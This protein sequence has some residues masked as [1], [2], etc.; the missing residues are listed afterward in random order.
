MDKK[1]FCQDRWSVSSKPVSSR[2]QGW[3]TATA[4][5][6]SL[7]WMATV[8][9]ALCLPRWILTQ[10]TANKQQQAPATA[11][12]QLL[13]KQ[14][15]WIESTAP[16]SRSSHDLELNFHLQGVSIWHT[17]LPLV[18]NTNKAGASWGL[19]SSSMEN[20]KL[21]QGLRWASIGQRKVCLFVFPP[22]PPSPNFFR[23]FALFVTL[24]DCQLTFLSPPTWRWASYLTSYQSVRS[25]ENGSEAQILN[26][27]EKWWFCSRRWCLIY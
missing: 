10:R 27:G 15:G 6:G 22:F 8:Q 7:S 19:E 14:G 2:V 4:P 23:T 12:G 17:D 24:S 9:M 18:G 13:G 21:L 3:G 11:K 1:K 16:F 25:R 26:G 20:L 5:A